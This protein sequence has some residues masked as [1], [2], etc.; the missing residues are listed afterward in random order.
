MADITYEEIRK[1]LCAEYAKAFK[2]T[3]KQAQRIF[4]KGAQW[5][6]CIVAESS[7]LESLKTLME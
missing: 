3:V 5:Q 7:A 4:D 2:I 6:R 1:Q